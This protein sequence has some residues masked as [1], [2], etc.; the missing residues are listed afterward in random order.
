ML[1]FEFC[2]S[3][4]FIKYKQNS[5]IFITA[6]LWICFDSVI[7]NYYF[8]LQHNIPDGAFSEDSFP[9]V[10]PSNKAEQKT[11]DTHTYMYNSHLSKII[12]FQRLYHVDHLGILCSPWTTVSPKMSKTRWSWGQ[13]FSITPSWPVVSL[14]FARVAAC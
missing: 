8:L 1:S 6:I 9:P 3:T 2:F 10:I 12:S 7:T 14:A 5:F 11:P 13:R 4:R